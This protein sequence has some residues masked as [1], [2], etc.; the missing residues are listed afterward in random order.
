MSVENKK[1]LPRLFKPSSDF[2]QNIKAQPDFEI[3]QIVNGLNDTK[4]FWEDVQKNKQSLPESLISDMDNKI[5]EIKEYK[6]QNLE[7]IRI[8]KRK[9]TLEKYNEF[10]NKDSEL[11]KKAGKEY[12]K[13]KKQ[14]ILRARQ[15]KYLRETGYE[16]KM[17]FYIAKSFKYLMLGI[18]IYYIGWVLFAE[19]EK[20]TRV[21]YQ[22][23]DSNGNIVTKKGQVCGDARHKINDRWKDD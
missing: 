13:M 2:I 8:V 7:C 21:T 20:C 1:I 16:T 22:D 17:G 15:R 5:N 14:G 12:A 11:N 18:F 23:F 19:K 4:K 6:K 9:I 10:I 3:S